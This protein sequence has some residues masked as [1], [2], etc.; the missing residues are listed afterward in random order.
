MQFTRT[1]TDAL[2]GVAVIVVIISHFMGGG[3][4]IR[5]FTPL[6]GIGVGMFL[7]LSGYGINESSHINGLESFWKKKIVRI[8]ILYLLWCLLL[9]ILRIFD[10]MH[11]PIFP[12]YWYLEY[13]VLWYFIYWVSR[14]VV[15]K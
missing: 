3:Y 13:L 5:Y 8:G 12:R 2:K 1:T 7:F 14:L 10:T 11:F 4:G 9:L 15:P 6:G